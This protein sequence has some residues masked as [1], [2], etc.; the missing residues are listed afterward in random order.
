MRTISVGYPEDQP[1]ASTDARKKAEEL[2]LMVDA[3]P[4]LVFYKD[5]DNCILRFNRAVRE[6]FD[7]DSAGVSLTDA[8]HSFGNDGSERDQADQQALRSGT[9]SVGAIERI[10]IAKTGWR[11]FEVS[12]LPQLNP[13]GQVKGLVIVMRDITEQKHLEAQLLQAQKLESIGRLAGGVAHDFNNILTSMFGLISAAQRSLS[14]DSMAHEYISLM[15]LAVEGGANLTKQLLTFARRQMIAPRVVDLNEV[16]RETSALFSRT[17]GAHIEL[18]LQLNVHEVLVRVDPSQISQLLMNLALNSRDAMP[19]AGKLSLRTTVVDW[20]K[21]D[22][23]IPAALATGRYAKLEVEDTGEGLTEEAQLHLFEPFFTNKA[24]GQGTGLGLA[25]C[26]GIVKQNS[27]HI[28]VESQRGAGTRFTIYLPKAD[29]PIALL[30]P[31]AT[32]TRIVEGSETILLAEDDDLVRYLAVAALASSGYRVIEA[33]HGAEAIQAANEHSGAIH[34]L[35]TD[36]I[37]PQV[38][39]IDLAELLCENRPNIAILYI[40]GYAGD[41]L[42]DIENG[43]GLLLKPFTSDDLLTRVREILDAK[44]ANLSQP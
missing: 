2:Q 6:A 42:P 11:W 31:P 13:A 32:T 40:T 33:A 10:L 38:G 19:R 20:A 34:L 14:S 8:I 43:T 26:Y 7:P 15:Q 29:T 30:P 37:M 27:G 3:L 1:V 35:L 44:A 17:L 4:A 24:L 18:E 21:D 9:S 5:A 28:T 41:S 25:I 39:G 12:R 23:R 16:V 22:C 36:I